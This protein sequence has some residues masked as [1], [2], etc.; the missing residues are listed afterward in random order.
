MKSP[1]RTGD[2]RGLSFSTDLSFPIVRIQ[3]EQ[4]EKPSAAM[5]D[6][7]DEETFDPIKADDRKYIDFRARWLGVTN[8]INVNYPW[9]LII[10]SMI[11]GLIV[12]AIY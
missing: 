7:S 4:N 10:L 11:F 3:S 12:V 8:W 1:G 6:W 2:D 9:L 5:N